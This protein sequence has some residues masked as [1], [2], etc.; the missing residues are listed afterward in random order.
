MLLGRV[1]GYTATAIDGRHVAVVMRGDM[2]PHSFLT[3]D[4]LF[5]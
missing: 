1:R 4:C 2:T 5:H 3:N